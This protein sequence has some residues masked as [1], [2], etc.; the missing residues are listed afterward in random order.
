MS[1]LK[2][3]YGNLSELNEEL[4]SYNT[5]YIDR[6]RISDDGLVL[7]KNQ[8]VVGFMS[9]ENIVGLFRNVYISKTGILLTNI[10]Q[11]KE[12]LMSLERFVSY[13]GI[14]IISQVD[15]IFKEFNFKS[16]VISF[17]GSKQTVLNSINTDTKKWLS[18]IKK[19]HRYYVKKALNSDNIACESKTIDSSD[20]LY[21][22]KLYE[23]YAEN[24]GIKGVKLLF[25]TKND[26]IK[27]IN[28]NLQN[29]IITSCFKDDEISYFC[30]VHSNKKVA[31]YIMAVTTQAGMSSYASYMGVYKLYD[32]LYSH[33]FKFL[34][35]GG[36][37]LVNNHGVYLFKRG[38]S[39]EL[40]ESPRYMLI[41]VGLIARVLKSLIKLRLFIKFR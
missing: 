21:L 39:G 26:F 33:N 13:E 7:L 17:F 3:R 2:W 11:Y 23:I 19:K 29:I 36:V 14:T 35:F 12:A 8:I 27:F 6:A 40:I 4:E 25:S 41:G 9:I 10:S 34:N 20:V 31:N 16:K 30:I 1:N 22:D 5:L 24:M 18:Q 28:R 37:D 38:F 15:F 32:Y